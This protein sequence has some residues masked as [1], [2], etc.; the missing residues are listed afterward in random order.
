MREDCGESKVGVERD[1]SGLWE[2][3]SGK[4]GR[5]KMEVGGLVRG[6][7]CYY[8]TYRACK[9]FYALVSF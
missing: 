5:K 4:R 1:K 8:G 6:V 3:E 2:E 9:I 7:N